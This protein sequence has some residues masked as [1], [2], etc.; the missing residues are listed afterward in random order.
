MFFQG[1]IQEGISTAVGQQKLLLCFVTDGNDESQTWEDEYLRDESVKD[2]IATKAI[3]LRLQAGSDE[4]GYLAQ[5]FPLPKTP[6]IVIM[7][8]GEL[9]EYIASGTAKEDFLR[10]VANAF[11]AGGNAAAQVPGPSAPSVGAATATAGPAP[12]AGSSAASPTSVPSGSPESDGSENVRRILAER[13]AKAQKEAAARQAREAEAAAVA[14]AAAAAATAAKGKGKAVAETA[15]VP[16]QTDVQRAATELI[17]KKKAQQND[18]RRRILKRIEDDKAARRE[19]AAQRKKQ[20]L[21]DL[22]AVDSHVREQEKAEAASRS[23]V[24]RP[25]A[26]VAIQ[27]RLS[28]GSTL[29]NKFQTTES[30]KDIRT[31]V[32]QERSDG[33]GPYLLKQILRPAPNKNIDSTEE[34]KSLGELGLS[35]SSTLLLIPIHRYATAYESQNASQGF[36][37]HIMGFILGLFAWLAGIVGLGGEAPPPTASASSQQPANSAAALRN[38]R[39]HAFQNPNDKRGDQQLYNGNSLNFEPRPDEDEK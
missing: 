29:R 1:S 16:P 13:A 19:L 7:K 26:T 39:V 27:V 15:V 8:H 10:R 2:L 23:S 14:A 6:T 3:A 35:P 18:E 31:W 22:A 5:I 24:N 11:S 37:G 30:I 21:E 9:K 20:R 12:N 33:Q 25:S 17:K 32:D 28:D 34:D 36:F 4:A 38:Q